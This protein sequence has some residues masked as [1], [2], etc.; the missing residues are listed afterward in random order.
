MEMSEPEFLN[1]LHREEICG[2]LLDLH[3]L[4]VSARNGCMDVE[5][6][7]A[8][9][10]PYAVEEVHLAG[11]EEFRGFY[12]DSHSRITPDEVWDMA[13]EFLPKCRNLRA[14][15]FEYNDSYFGHGINVVDVRCELEK[16]HVLAA[17]CARLSN[18]PI[19]CV[20]SC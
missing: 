15:T 3:N 14:I 19:P 7:F 9:L 12:T 17:S 4:L 6:Y 1:R 8:S 13:H 16:M 18:H 5:S 20:V 11:G 10:D 2:T